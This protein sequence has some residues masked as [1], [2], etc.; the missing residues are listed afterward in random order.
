[1]VA[2]SVMLLFSKLTGDYGLALP[3]ALFWRQL[4]PAIGILAWLAARGQLSRLRTERFWIHARR[5]FIGTV[6]MFGTLGVV[7]ILPLAEATILGF[8]TPMFAVVL[9][10]LFLR[11]TV[12]PWRWSAVA[13]GL[14]GVM[15]IVGPDR[16][17]LP[18]NGVVVGLFA[19]FSVAL[20]SIQLRDLG[21]TEEPLRVVFYFSLLGALL[22]LPA[23]LVT[24]RA[25][26]Q[27]Q[28]LLL[29]GLG[30]TGIVTQL[31]LTAALRYGSVASVI[32]MDYSQLI[33]ST[34]WGYLIWRQL[35][36]A[37]SWLGAPLIIA[38][39]L[40]IA[41]REHV[42]HRRSVLDPAT[43]PNAD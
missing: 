16:A 19:A 36:P 2:M 3:E 1:M 40:I 33:W 5:A 27:V 28:W 25:H 31:L 6:G 39:G 12:G 9:A 26:S 20:V 43:A 23:A 4:L 21:R 22:L 10:A 42:L 24:G 35:P 18:L 14:V 34:L 13:V 37:T 30:A 15:V 38:A 7:R 29:A 8:T 32:V 41:W 11:E 17:H